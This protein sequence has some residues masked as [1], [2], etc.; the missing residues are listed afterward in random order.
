MANSVIINPIKTIEAL[1]NELLASILRMTGQSTYARVSKQ[2]RDVQR[3][4]F[5]SLWGEYNRNSKI[6]GFM[7]TTD[8]PETSIEFGEILCHT[9]A[10]VRNYYRK[11]SDV[12][13]DGF[14]RT[15]L[16][17]ACDLERLITQTAQQESDRNL[18]TLWNHLPPDIIQQLAALTPYPENATNAQIISAI[19]TGIQNNRAAILSVLSQVTDLSLDGKDLSAL[20][21]EIGLFE[22]LQTLNLSD[23]QIT[24]LPPEIGNLLNLQI[25][26]LDFNQITTLPPEIG[27]LVNLQDLDLCSNRVTTL[28]PEIVSLVNLHDLDLT[29]NHITTLPAEIGILVNLQNLNISANRITILPAELGHLVNLQTLDLSL[30]PITYDARAFIANYGRQNPHCQI[31]VDPTVFGSICETLVGCNRLIVVAEGFCLAVLIIC[32]SFDCLAK[33]LR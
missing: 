9:V 10:N 17:E 5:S 1:P 13:L 33:N 24:T 14:P 8:R 4:N 27:H 19:R 7:P 18:A 12:Q 11:F 23:N 22:N 3:V 28:P 15:S 16:I 25:L 20:P 29:D 21:P 30:N 32:F 26:H 31:Y 2:W 6:R